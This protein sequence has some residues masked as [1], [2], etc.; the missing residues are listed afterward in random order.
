M[1]QDDSS[2]KNVDTSL[3]DFGCEEH[4]RLLDE[5]GK[6]VQRLLELHQ[7]QYRAIVDGE[8]ECQRFDILIHVGNE[9]KQSAKYAYLRHVE[10]H[11]CLTR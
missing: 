9:E 1:Y 10:S 6:A 8:S 5:F 4:N 7:Q 2:G 11:G 3:R